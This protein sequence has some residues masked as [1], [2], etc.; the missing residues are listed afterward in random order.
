MWTIVFFRGRKFTRIVTAAWYI[1]LSL[2]ECIISRADENSIF[3]QQRGFL[4][5]T[6]STS[7]GFVLA[8]TCLSYCEFNI[9]LFLHLPVYLG[10]MYFLS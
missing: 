5:A 4:E 9:C 3:Y 1:M 7:A 2:V 8:T 6:F 10:T